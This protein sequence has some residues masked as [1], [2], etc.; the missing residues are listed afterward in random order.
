MNKIK[1]AWGVH[2]SSVEGNLDREG[3]YDG[4]NDEPQKVF[5]G[6]KVD[7][8]I[9]HQRPSSLR[10]GFVEVEVK[11]EEIDSSHIVKPKK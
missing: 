6:I 9:Y 10:D 8:A 4:S 2:Y 1:K 5:D 11:K 7:T 3:W